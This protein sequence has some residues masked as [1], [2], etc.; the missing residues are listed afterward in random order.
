[1]T[2]SAMD[3]L[4]RSCVEDV[5]AACSKA[6]A[7]LCTRGWN[8]RM[9]RQRREKLPAT[10]RFQQQYNP[11]IEWRHRHHLAWYFADSR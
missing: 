5:N 10:I 1:M 9:G 2:S 3:A 8:V 4:A 6:G 7:K 11:L